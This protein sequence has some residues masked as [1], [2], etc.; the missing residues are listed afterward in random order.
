MPKTIN[1]I[2][3]NGVF[4]PLEAVSLK[5]HEKVKLDINLDERLRN[6]FK[7]LTES[8]YKRTDRY[9]SEEI[10]ANITEAFREVQ[11]TYRAKKRSRS[12]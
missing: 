4:K 8:I 7:K 11:E 2:Y 1:A 12:N 6:Q 9:S 3:E 5:E 10:E